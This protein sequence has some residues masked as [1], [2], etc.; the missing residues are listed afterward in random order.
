MCRAF[1]VGRLSEAGKRATGARPR[2]TGTWKFQNKAADEFTAPAG[3]L[4]LLFVSGWSDREVLLEV[5]ESS[6]YDGLHTLIAERD[7][8]SVPGAEPAEAEQL[9]A[10]LL[11]LPADLHGPCHL[12]VQLAGEE[13]LRAGATVEVRRGRVVSSSILLEQDPDTWATGSPVEWC[14]AVVDPTAVRLETGGD[15]E[16]VGALLKALNERLFSTAS[17]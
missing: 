10:P 15:T 1:G 3:A 6:R 7:G 11:E 2:L 13:P 17:G 4:T 8:R 5:L 9:A 14:D 12:S 16:L